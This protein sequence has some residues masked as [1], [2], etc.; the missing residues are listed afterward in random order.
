MTKLKILDALLKSIIQIWTYSGFYKNNMASHSGSDI[1]GGNLSRCDSKFHFTPFPLSTK[2]LTDYLEME[3]T[4]ISSGPVKVCLCKNM[5]PDCGQHSVTLS[6]YRGQTISLSTIVLGQLNYPVRSQLDILDSQVPPLM[7]D[8]NNNSI[9][10]RSIQ[11][12]LGSIF[13]HKWY[14]KHYKV[15]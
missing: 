12:Q 2:M 1:F 8:K 7:L 5:I 10:C 11:F 6:A 13:D 15:H 3:N 4:R 9:G 14:R